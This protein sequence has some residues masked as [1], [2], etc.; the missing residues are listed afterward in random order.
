MNRF[1]RKSDQQGFTIIELMVVV[2][3]VAVLAAIAVPMYGRDVKNA[4]LTEAPNR[5]DEDLT[6]A[7][8]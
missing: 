1:R 8:P 6:A 3:I 4:R 7:T 5:L 2:V